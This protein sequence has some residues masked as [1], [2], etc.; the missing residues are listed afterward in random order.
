ME[1][2]HKP[3][4]VCSKLDQLDCFF[5]SAYQSWP[6]RLFVLIKC[7]AFRVTQA[8]LVNKRYV[9]VWL[10]SPPLLSPLVFCGYFRAG[11][12]KMSRGKRC[13]TYFL[14]THFTRWC[15]IEVARNEPLNRATS[16]HIG[17]PDFF[18][19]EV[20][21]SFFVL[22]LRGHFSC[23]KN[24]IWKYEGKK[25][26]IEKWPLSL[27]SH[28]EDLQTGSGWHTLKITYCFICGW[29]LSVYLKDQAQ[30]V[31]VLNAI[32]HFCCSFL[33]I[34]KHCWVAARPP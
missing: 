29:S 11:R 28:N 6:I 14:F 31:L 12:K 21:T 27:A 7:V 13:A 5:W 1:I 16:C 3:L 25:S 24:K 4:Q 23:S 33:H 2:F 17:W 20:G 22:T 9:S 15:M 19:L 34:S 26:K 30:G 32:F 18:S 10:C 8:C